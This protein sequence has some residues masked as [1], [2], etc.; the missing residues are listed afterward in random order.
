VPQLEAGRIIAEQDGL[1]DW[2]EVLR[3]ELLGPLGMYDT[4]YTAEAIAN[5]PD[6]AEGHI[7][8][9][10]QGTSRTTTVPFTP[11][12]P[13][14]FGGAGDINSTVEDLLK[15]FY[16]QTHDGKYPLMRDGTY[17]QE[18]LVTADNLAFTLKPQ[19][20]IGDGQFYARGW[21][22]AP[23]TKKTMIVWHKGTTYGFGAVIGW[24]FDTQTGVVILTNEA[25][26][27]LPSALARWVLERITGSNPPDYVG[28][29]FKHAKAEYEEEMRVFTR[30][31][32]PRPSRLDGLDGLYFNPSF[33]DASLG[34][35]GGALFV[36]LDT[37]AELKLEPFD[38]DRFTMRLQPTPDFAAL[39]EN[40]QPFPLGFAQFEAKDGRNRFSLQFEDGP[41]YEFDQK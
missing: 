36:K 20:P 27:G 10:A 8:W 32:D 25:D 11:I 2:N 29:M 1:Q 37:G 22:L 21:V 14:R 26:R 33:G 9:M 3:E 17:E 5:A 7:W 16:L 35:D 24:W 4:S 18:Q 39:A 13:Y 28:V 19:I 30:P 6:H 41:P 12:F 38:G 34:R 31:K 40:L 23:V 15:W